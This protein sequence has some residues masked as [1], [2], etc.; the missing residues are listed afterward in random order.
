MQVSKP[1]PATCQFITPEM[2]LGF[3][4]FP[5]LVHKFIMK[6]TAA[7][8]CSHIVLQKKNSS[9]QSNSLSLDNYKGQYGRAK[10]GK[11]N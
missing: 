10:S 6:N 11:G 8:S 2:Q 5:Y 1:H 3:D 4:M 9:V 7:L